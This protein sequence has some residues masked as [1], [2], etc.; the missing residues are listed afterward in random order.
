MP[1]VPT[2]FNVRVFRF[3]KSVIP[4]YF[5]ENRDSV[6]MPRHWYQPQ[7]AETSVT[8]VVVNPSR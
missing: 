7:Y 4:N 2:V 5:W 6:L 8:Y 3:R 1:A